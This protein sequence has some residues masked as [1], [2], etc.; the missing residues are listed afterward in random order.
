MNSKSITRENGFVAL[1]LSLIHID[2]FANYFDENNFVAFFFFFYI[3][4]TLPENHYQWYFFH[5]IKVVV[6]QNRAKAFSQAVP[7]EP[8]SVAM[9]PTRPIVAV[10]GAKV[11]LIEIFWNFICLWRHTYYSVV[12]FTPICNSRSVRR[13][14]IPWKFFHFY[15]AKVKTVPGISTY[16]NLKIKLNKSGNFTLDNLISHLLIWSNVGSQSYYSVTVYF[17]IGIMFIQY[18][19]DPT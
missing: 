2:S 12:I 7:F 1:F 15:H 4:T 5:P 16:L 18:R 8:V 6:F 3:L 11:R 9:H 17:V 13:Y 14:Q 10:C 19:P